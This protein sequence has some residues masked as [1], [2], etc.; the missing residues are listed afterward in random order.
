[1]NEHERAEG[2]AVSTNASGSANVVAQEIGASL[3]KA[4]A[5]QGMSIH[6]VGARLK[7]P[8]Q[9]VDA[10]ESGNVGALPD[11]TFAK[12]LMRAYARLLQVDIDSLLARFHAQAAPPAPEV[13]IRRQGSLNA[14]FDDRRRFRSSGTSGSG[15]RWVWL[16]LVAAVVCAGALFGVDHVKQWLDAREQQFTQSGTEAA[17]EAESGTVTAVLPHVM[18]GAASEAPGAMTGTEG[19]AAGAATGTA[20]ASA[21]LATPLAPV[22][23]P[24]AAA[25][26]SAVTAAPAAA[27]PAAT[28]AS[29][30][31]ELQ[32]R[33]SAPTWYEVRDASGK[34]VLGG[35]AKAGDEVVGGGTAPYKV[36]IGN[37]K[38]VA[39]MTR[40][41][42]PVDLQAANRNNVARLTLP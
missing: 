26:E 10:I 1:M 12:G 4:R 14:S 29:A 22:T 41:G 19:A 20:N 39:A 13:A 11:L 33:F 30:A 24:S 37:V 35:T 23:G 18:G 25:N 28:A 36:V 21:T 34:V 31:G 6:D 42:E 5:A 15:G 2:Q 32:L 3:A 16:A 8:A 40:N 27:G 9:K 38:G 17:P 7:V